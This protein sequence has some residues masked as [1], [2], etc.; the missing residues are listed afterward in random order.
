MGKALPPTEGEGLFRFSSA[1][2]IICKARS[3][4]K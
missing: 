2:P 1:N 4:D 3:T